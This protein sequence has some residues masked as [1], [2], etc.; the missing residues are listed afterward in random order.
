MTRKPD[1]SKRQRPKLWLVDWKLN[2][3]TKQI[4][5]T[6]CEVEGFPEWRIVCEVSAVDQGLLIKRLAIKPH[7]DDVPDGGVTT[8]LLRQLRTNDLVTSLRAA[9]R[10]CEGYLGFTPDLRANTRVGKRRRDTDVQYAEWAQA[11]VDALIKSTTPIVTLSH[12]SGLSVS[13]VRN[14]I[15]SCRQRGMLTSPEESGRAGGK[16]TEKAIKVL[17]EIES[18][19][20]ASPRRQVAGSVPWS[21]P[22]GAGK[23]LRPQGRRATMAS[24]ANGG[25]GP[26]RMG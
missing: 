14:L 16:L 20:P 5:E 11:Y 3:D 22:Q 18:E 1:G 12:Q 21:G 9:A 8:K 6:T 13:R 15:H 24:R 17:K 7:A 4:T 2:Y 10:Q 19:H 25:E 23:A 26:R